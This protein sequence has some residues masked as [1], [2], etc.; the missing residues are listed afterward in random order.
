MVQLQY[1]IQD[2]LAFILV[3]KDQIILLFMV[4]GQTELINPITLNLPKLTNLDIQQVI[5]LLISLTL[6]II[7]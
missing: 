2:M 4:I 5:H 1:S 7:L 6:K 3:N